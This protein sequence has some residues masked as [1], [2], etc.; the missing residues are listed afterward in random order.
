MEALERQLGRDLRMVALSGSSVV[1]TTAQFVLETLGV[2]EP[3]RVSSACAGVAPVVA[4]PVGPEVE[5]LGATR[6]ATRRGGP[7]RCRRV[8]AAPP[9]TRRT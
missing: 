6:R 3:Q 9:G 1:S 7:S 8:R 2:V 4:E 5:R